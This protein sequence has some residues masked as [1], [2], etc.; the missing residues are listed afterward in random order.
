M[1]NNEEIVVIIAY[2]LPMYAFTGLA[3][4]DGLTEQI[5][6]RFLFSL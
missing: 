5:N 2:A 6:L 1:E 3:F 4:V